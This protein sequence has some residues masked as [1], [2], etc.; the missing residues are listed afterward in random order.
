M[1]PRYVYINNKR[2]PTPEYKTWQGMKDRCYNV[3]SNRYKYY[4][5]RGI[6]VC[7]RWLQSFDNF[8]SDMGKRP[9]AEL[10]IDRVDNNKDYSPSNCRWTDRSTQMINTRIRKDNKTGYRGISWSSRQRKYIV[11]ISRDNIRVFAGGFNYLEDAV[12]ALNNTKLRI[13]V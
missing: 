9:S 11:S 13:G 5:A 3:N 6:K 1:N 8:L 10:S 7:D 2:K 4:G 12:I